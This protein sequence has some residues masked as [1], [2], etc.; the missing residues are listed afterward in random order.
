M[1]AMIAKSPAPCHC[2][3]EIPWHLCAVAGRG[4]RHHC[5]CGQVWYWRSPR[6]MANTRWNGRR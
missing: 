5:H 2:G 3:S 4:F 1:D 6:S